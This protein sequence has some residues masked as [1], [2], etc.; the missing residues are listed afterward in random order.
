VFVYVGSFFGL[1]RLRSLDLS[2]NRLRSLD[3][4]TFYGLGALTQLHIRHNHLVDVAPRALVGVG[5][6]LT[7]LDLGGNRL[8]SIDF[9]SLARL[10][11]LR[12]VGLDSNPWTCDCRL[13]WP[14]DVS[15]A[16]DVLKAAWDRIV[17]E[18]PPEASRKVL[19]FVLDRNSSTALCSVVA[20]S[21]TQAPT[22]SPPLNFIDQ[23]WLYVWIAMAVLLAVG[24]LAATT[25]T[26]AVY[27]SRHSAVWSPCDDIVDASGCCSDTRRPIDDDDDVSSAGARDVTKVGHDY[28]LV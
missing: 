16:S 25:L 3:D 10:G 23:L 15:A 9:G 20:S 1:G 6:S 8:R 28:V 22:T 17:C 21:S 4:G 7:H 24:A 18:D 12:F 26:V 27:R 13:R 11:H 2:N 5:P 19:Q 14:G